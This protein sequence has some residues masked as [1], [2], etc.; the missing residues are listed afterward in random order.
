LGE[1]A[2]Q[3]LVVDDERFFREAIREILSAEGLSC[4]ECE[5]GERALE[6]AREPGLGVVVLDIRL[7]GID[8]IEVLRRL[9]ELRPSL[10]VIML[11]ASTDQE[12][13]LEALRLGACDYLAKPLHDEELVLA[14]RRAAESYDLAEDR[15]R[16]RARFERLASQ[17]EEL[18]ARVGS[19][20]PS[21][22]RV[23]LREGAARAAADVLEA[24]KTSLMLLND[25]GS[26]LEVAAAVGRECG[27]GEMDPVGF[28][29][30]LAGLML[31]QAEPLV[32]DDVEGEPR[33]AGRASPGRYASGSFALAP[34]RAG[35]RTLGVL[36]AADRTGGGRFGPEDVPLLRLLAMQI[37]QLL[38]TG[39]GAEEELAEPG[40]GEKTLPLLSD[41][42][43][44]SA[45][46]DAELARAICEAVV[47]EVE[48]ERVIRAALQPLA[49]RL[50][51]AP[52]SLFLRDA[53]TGELEC[54][55][56][57]DAGRRPERA[58]LAA[59]RGLTATVLQTGQLVASPEPERDPRFDAQVDT[60]EDGR[61][62]P[63]L[64]GPL[65]L[66]GKVVGVFRAFPEDP[67]TLSARTG[68]VLGAALSAA[69]RNVL[70]YRSLL[71]SIEE[72]AEARREARHAS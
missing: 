70:L 39:P 13:V 33:L 11:S 42:P 43:D 50:P 57:C 36:C 38:A 45:D 40:G 14:V 15:G 46:R 35:G 55:G 12:L 6:L 47:S 27:P 22:R 2:P 63:L 61:A 32:V 59:D 67:G 23:A 1:H 18:A 28:G 4:V 62:G 20:P 41:L 58:R 66:R 56:A 64:C 17:L 19:A 26:R 69:V 37:A 53:R 65:R 44:P 10:R 54:Q 34:L 16:L 24:E 51:A 5:D 49:E 31:E 29:E 60:P 9:R 25:D 68:E 48:P 8:G 7:P 3:V 52:V 71:Q 21:G 30:R 72:V